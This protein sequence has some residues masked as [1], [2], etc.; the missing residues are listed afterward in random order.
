[1][2]L[3]LF[4]LLSVLLTLPLAFRFT[5]SLP[6]GSGDVWQ[7]YWNLWW[8]KTALFDLHVHPYHTNLLFHPHGADLIFHT[9][10]PFN[11]LVSMPVNAW[12]GMA[13]AYNFSVLLALTLSGY[14]GWLLGREVSGDS[15]GGV[16]AGLVFAFFPQHIE[17]TF[18]H[19]NLLSTQFLP[20]S[21]YYLIRLLRQGG[22]RA[23]IGFGI[24]FGLNALCS[25]HL[26]IKLALCAAFVLA[27]YWARSERRAKAVVQD[28]ALA[29]LTAVLA[30]G[31]FVA[32]LVVEIASGAEYFQKPA[33]DRGIDAAYLLTPHFG[34][35]LWGGL[36]LDSYLERAYQASGFIS[37]LGVVPLALAGLALVRRR[38]M[39][40]F[41]AALAGLMLVLSLGSPMW[42][43]G[44]LLEGVWLPFELLR[45][46]PGLSVLRVANRF[47]IL[48]S[49]ALAALT[50]L[51]W[52][53]LRNRGDGVFLAVAGLILFEYAWLPYPM[54]KADFA[55]SYARM[56]DGPLLRIGAVLDIPFNQRSQSVHNMAAQTVHGRP[57][58]AGYLSTFPPETEA[59][60]ANEPALADLA[61][62]P[63]LA[64][65]IDFRRLVQLGFDTVVLH[66]TRTNNYRDQAVAAVPRD[67]LLELKEAMRMGGIPDEKL[68]EIRRQLE[69]H[70]GPAVFEDDRVAIFYLRAGAGLR[71]P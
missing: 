64:R 40:W 41:W 37:Y 47:L 71:R 21:L 57:I 26:G 30:V 12:L 48:T 5:D 70:N 38:R 24:T 18:E 65:P 2:V 31:P 62:V 51:G 39:A 11:M 17:Q 32:P 49:L 52:S 33:V 23:A 69:E 46:M 7:N 67:R 19:I 20:W 3:A 1:M 22:Q 53:A 58:A 29:A 56:L 43:N 15:R 36:V 68:A 4:A 6:A 61:G 8:W 14:G 27:A 9:H 16:L 45:D 60:I 10:S 54:Q 55:P 59:A 44:K 13:A 25:W 63:S 50:A 35:P 66:K 42:W 34:H 28:L